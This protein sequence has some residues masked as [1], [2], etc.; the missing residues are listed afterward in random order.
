MTKT[1]KIPET[2]LKVNDVRVVFHNSNI[3]MSNLKMI[4][5]IYDKQ[6]QLILIRA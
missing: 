3:N 2:N 4:F 1:Q 6:I 5:L